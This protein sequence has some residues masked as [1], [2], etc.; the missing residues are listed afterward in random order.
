MKFIVFRTKDR[1]SGIAPCIDATLKEIFR[2]SWQDEDEEFAVWE[3]EFP[4]IKVFSAFVQMYKR[5]VVHND[6]SYFYELPDDYSDRQNSNL[7]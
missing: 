5:I 4:T 3:V 1:N 2:Y 7:S 6:I